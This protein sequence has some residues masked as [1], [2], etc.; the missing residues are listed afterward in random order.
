MFIVNSFPSNITQYIISNQI[1]IYVYIYM[2]SVITPLCAILG[3][4]PCARLI[5]VVLTGVILF[6]VVYH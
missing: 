4:I 6:E 2:Y 3:I 1:G 5:Y